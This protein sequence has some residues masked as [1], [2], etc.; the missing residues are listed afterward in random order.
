VPGSVFHSICQRALCC[1]S[2]TSSLMSL[3]TSST[4]CTPLQL[5]PLTYVLRI[6]T[7][8]TCIH[9]HCACVPVSDFL[10]AKRLLPTSCQVRF[11]YAHASLVCT[12]HTFCRHHATCSSCL[13]LLY[14]QLDVARRTFLDKHPG[15]KERDQALLVKGDH[16]KSQGTT[17]GIDWCISRIC[18]DRG[19]H[20]KGP[21]LLSFQD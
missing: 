4:L 8:R 14:V 5:Y 1:V 10:C 12:D 16:L 21:P 11:L 17:V 2:C 18:K 9:V 3:H 20:K 6:T 7:A 15:A 19:F 13:C